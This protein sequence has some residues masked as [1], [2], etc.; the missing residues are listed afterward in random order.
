[1]FSCAYFNNS[2]IHFILIGVAG[3]VCDKDRCLRS[4]VVCD[5][6]TQCEDSSDELPERCAAVTCPSDK[7]Q[8]KDSKQW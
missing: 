4:Q 7:F 8:C 2:F 5:G 6:L 3:F 1:M